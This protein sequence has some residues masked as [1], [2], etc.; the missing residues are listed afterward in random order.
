MRKTVSMIRP[1]IIR[2]MLV[3]EFAQLLRDKRMRMIVFGAPLIMLVVFGFAAS[4]DVKDVRITY[5]DSDRSSESRG[6]IE[7]ILASGHFNAQ[8]VPDS[9]S[10]GERF[11]Q[12]GEA[13]VYLHI[14]NGF[15]R[16]LNRGRSVPVQVII[17]GSDPNR[18]MIISSQIQKIAI[19]YSANAAKKAAPRMVFMNSGII[20]TSANPVSITE[21]AFFNESLESRV[22]FL[23]AILSLLTGL[24]ITMLTSMSI[25]KEK[26]SGT[27]EQI[28]VSPIRPIEYIL[29]K[30]IPFGI[31]AM[32]DVVL[33]TILMI[34]IF[35]VPFNGSMLFLLICSFIYVIAML[36]MGVWISTVSSTQQQA[37]LSTFLF[38]L[39]A[40][41]LSGFIFP[42]SSM[43]APVQV[44]TYADPLRFF[45][46]IVRGIFL[47]G[48]GITSLWKECAI[49]LV[50]GSV[51]L[52]LS[53]R[54]FS[55][56]FE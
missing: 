8:R 48:T 22:F 14:P 34:I 28:I 54:R 32:A 52:G 33:I 15:A 36:G 19:D 1:D 44:I 13:E 16:D 49:L 6:F 7:R 17:D 55:R 18:G 21:R 38:F 39:P 5:T 9:P 10:D 56:G 43:P 35:S 31:I 11:I 30:I 41:M 47:K 37:M 24:I 20:A 50:L 46:T 12:S 53:V 51:F 40:I 4:T 3:K 45:I 26:E 27:I 2:G 25:V 29:G 23:P 42:V